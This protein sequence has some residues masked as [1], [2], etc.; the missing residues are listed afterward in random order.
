MKLAYDNEALGRFCR[1]RGIARLEVFGSALRDDF[2]PDSDVDLLC[3]LRSDAKCTLLGW[4]DMQF[5][6]EEIFGRPV[7]LVSRW[8]IERS[9]NSYRRNAILSATRPLYVEG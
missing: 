7:D 3:T 8:A 9:N 6:L 2:R 5:K 4:A 1:E